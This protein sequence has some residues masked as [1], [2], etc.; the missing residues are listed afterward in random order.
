MQPILTGMRIIEGSAFI[1]APM[2][3]MTLA[4]LGADV[5]RFDQI[6][7]GI[8]YRRWPVTDKNNSIYWAEMN[9]GKR[10][11]AVNIRSDAGRE[12][13]ADLI[14]APG[15]NAGIFSTN[16]PATGMLAYEKL[17]LRR[18]DLIQ[19]EIVG[20]RHGTSALDY[21]VNA[22]VGFPFVTGRQDDER[23]VNHVLPAWDIA[24]AYHAA[25]DILA[26]DRY[27]KMHGVGQK[28]TLALADVALTSVG[29]LGLVGEV[30]INGEER[31]RWGN[32]LYGAFGRDFVTSDNERI[33]LIA[34]SIKQ[35]K[36]L[37]EAS[38]LQHEISKLEQQ[39]NLDFCREG[40]R[41]S[42]IEELCALFEPWVAKLPLSELSPL[43]DAHGICWEKYQTI[44]NLVRNDPDCSP[45]NP[46][47]ETIE[48][49]GIGEYPV[50]DSA[51]YFSSV[52]RTAPVRAPEV[53]EHTDEILSTI[54]N[55]DA[56]TIGKL[57]DDGIVA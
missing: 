51:A 21:T 29:H 35:W 34:A 28:I 44:G 13:L 22:K 50:P 57:H 19:H 30:H 23:P 33:M 2:C 53:G 45:E 7:G 37:V 9:K 52:D 11:I 43:L 36:G 32:Y 49:V 31:G 26:A 40:D 5:I 54:L 46:I 16:L 24:C 6:G 14:C 15:A 39:M 12:L 27:R 38:N 20:N 10:S 47:F 42:A 3:G 55:L 25:I 56:S 18:P 41:F 8:D 1:A 48:Q 17:S 4:Q